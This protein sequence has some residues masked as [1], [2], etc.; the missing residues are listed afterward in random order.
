MEHKNKMAKHNMRSGRPATPNEDVVPPEGRLCGTVP[1]GPCEDAAPDARACSGA[2]S[3]KKAMSSAAGTEI[4]ISH[5]YTRIPNEEKQQNIYVK[6][7]ID[8]LKAFVGEAMLSVKRN[9]CV[10]TIRLHCKGVDYLE[11][12]AVVLRHECSVN[13]PPSITRAIDPVLE[14]VNRQTGAI[15]YVK[16][17]VLFM[18]GCL[19]A[20][21]AGRKAIASRVGKEPGEWDAR[22]TQGAGDDADGARDH[23]HQRIVDFLR[24]SFLRAFHSSEL[25]DILSAEDAYLE[26]SENKVKIRAKSDAALHAAVS[27]FTGIYNNINVIKSSAR[28]DPSPNPPPAPLCIIHELDS[29]YV[30]GFLASVGLVSS[31]KEC[32]SKILLD[33]ETANFVCGKKCGKTNRI[34]KATNSTLQIVRTEELA[35]IFVKGAGGSVYSAL[36][37]LAGEFPISI[38]FYVDE[39]HHRRIIGAKGRT[40]QAIMRKYNVYV[41][42]TNGVSSTNNVALKTPRRNRESLERIKAEILTLATGCASLEENGPESDSEP[43]ST[44]AAGSSLGFEQFP[45]LSSLFCVACEKLNRWK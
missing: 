9:G 34:S 45:A 16:G 44:P 10:A 25:E 8:L 18:N 14:E 11:R 15:F 31:L 6:M 12:L 41:R 39:R 43:S 28:I 3:A 30:V 7:H 37:L 13:I 38:N 20:V 17:T 23:C 4:I 35:L 36:S 32:E 24:L 1:D 27:K 2:E 22:I 33:L 26:I 5:E 19:A 29:V 42:F 40:I 21:E